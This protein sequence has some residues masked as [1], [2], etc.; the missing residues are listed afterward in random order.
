MDIPSLEN[1]WS[2]DKTIALEETHLI[3]IRFGYESN[4]IC[5]Q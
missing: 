3:L 2:I 5:L 1:E 4:P